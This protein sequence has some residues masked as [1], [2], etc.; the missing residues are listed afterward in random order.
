MAQVVGLPTTKILKEKVNIHV[1]VLYMQHR[2]T[3][4]TERREGEGGLRKRELGGGG[5]GE[6]ENE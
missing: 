4:H 6:R 1:H 5:A 2:K 3:V